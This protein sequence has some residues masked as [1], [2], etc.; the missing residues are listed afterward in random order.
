VSNSI[1]LQIR[2][3]FCQFGELRESIISDHKG[4]PEKIEGDGNPTLVKEISK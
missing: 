3:F 4:F 1:K 2:L